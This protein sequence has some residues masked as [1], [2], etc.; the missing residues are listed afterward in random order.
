MT[1]LV[2]LA[3]RVSAI[4][5]KYSEIYSS[6]FSWSFKKSIAQPLIGSDHAHCRHQ[7]ECFTLNEELDQVLAILNSG[8]E[9]EPKTMFG[10]E[11]VSVFVDYIQALST[12]ISRLS[13]ICDHRCQEDMGVIAYSEE[14]SRADRTAYDE[15]I[16][17]YQ[18]LGQQLNLLF[19]KL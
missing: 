12:A 14:Q 16:Q 10:R 18:K 1:H 11:F 13:V 7:K 4:H 15:S 9:F 8:T 2:T 3:H 19:K 6:L 17:V 5:A